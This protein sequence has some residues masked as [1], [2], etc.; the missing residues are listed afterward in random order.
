MDM[1]YVE[2]ASQIVGH[3]LVNKG[4]CLQVAYMG[5]MAAWLDCSEYS[6]EDL[7]H[8]YVVYYAMIG[9]RHYIGKTNNLTRRM[10]EHFRTDRRL[11]KWIRKYGDVYYKPLTILNTA[12]AA[13]EFE[14]RL[15][16]A[17]E[18]ICDK[19]KLINKNI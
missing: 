19:D 6:V 12:D 3:K 9:D 18:Y 4:T 7:E 1:N 15:I 8:G 2:L 10:Q 16:T 5:K 13:R 17:M 14:R 11:Y